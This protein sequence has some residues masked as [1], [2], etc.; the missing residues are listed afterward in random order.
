MLGAEGAEVMAAWQQGTVDRG[1]EI[2]C[3][4]GLGEQAEKNVQRKQLMEA[5]TLIRAEVE[6]FSG[7]PI[8]DSALLIEELYRSLDVG[9]PQKNEGVMR[10]LQQMVM[11]LAGQLEQLTGVNPLDPKGQQGGGQ[12]GPNPAEGQA[13]SE[14]NLN[15]GAR[16][17]T[18]LPMSG[19]NGAP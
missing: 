6:P 7:T 10:A 8:Y 9:A 2:S 14:E 5:I 15:A 4:F 11:E 18:V 16:R 12:G 19:A 17:D 13:P 3:V 1:D